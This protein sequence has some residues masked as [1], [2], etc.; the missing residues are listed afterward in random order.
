[1]D[2]RRERT[3]RQVLTAGLATAALALAGCVGEGEREPVVQPPST[4]AGRPRLDLPAPVTEG[5]VSLEAA[6]SRRRS[7]RTF[8][9]EPLSLAQ[10]GQLMWAAQGVTADWGGRTAPSAGA[11][12]PLEIYAAMPD[13][14]L[15]YL[16]DGHRAE[17]WAVGDA[18][19]ALADAAPSH[20]TVDGGAV[21]FV[22]GVV[23]QRTAH[24]YGG[25]A[26]R[27]VDLEAGH[28]TQNLL[29]QAAVLGLGAVPVGAF[30]DGRV[31]R[32]ILL[33]PNVAPRYLVPVGRP[34]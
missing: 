18:R 32:Q 25:R 2:G 29:L 33:L 12:Y 6:L 19:A 22:I 30:D 24:K 8:S 34:A 7:V 5:S 14:V 1:V 16:P 13:R 4:G 15:H 27:Y 21:V 28:A 17:V 10:V 3:R 26:G 9:S 11:S 20:D 23:R 31:A